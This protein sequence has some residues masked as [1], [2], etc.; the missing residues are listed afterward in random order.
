MFRLNEKRLD[1][2]N[3]FLLGLGFFCISITWS[4]YNSFVPVFLNKY[5]ESAFIIGIIM[6][7]DNIA[8]ITLQPFFGALSDR[9]DTRHGRRMPFL[10]VGIPV[11]AAFFSL[12]PYEFSLVSLIAIVMC[13]NIAMSVYRAPTIALMPD[14]TP[15]P[16]R[17]K[18]NGIIN[19][20]GG[21]G[22]LLAYFIGSKI[23]DYDRHLPFAGTAILMV[24]A[25]IIL[26]RSIKEPPAPAEENT[27]GSGLM[28]AFGEILS[29]RDRSALYLLFAI[30]F[31]FIGYQGVETLFT[32]YGVKYLGIKESAAA[33]TLGFFSFSFLVFAIPSGFLATRIGRKRTIKAGLAGL[34]AVFVLILFSRN[35]TVI[36]GL[37]LAG[38]MFWAFVNINSYPM[39]V[40]M[41]TDDKIG[42]YTG[43]YYFFSSMA[44]IL[45]P[46]FFGRVIDLVGYGVLFILALC[47]LLLAFICIT[48][49]KKGEYKTIYMEVEK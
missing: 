38:G 28:A 32:L 6:T 30:F 23:Y 13:F 48:Q 33:L 41:T 31:W 22:A 8:A 49:V 27:E 35:I 46:P 26:Y 20:M 7:F 19:F 11:S 17:S 45:G 37:M 34:M 18:A 21:L 36:R 10:L 5:I 2:L 42:A 25:V 4:L 29:D 16:L 15:S 43:I 3:T 40:E 1:Y 14:L 47:F 12:I 39:V 44:A 24:L 9:T